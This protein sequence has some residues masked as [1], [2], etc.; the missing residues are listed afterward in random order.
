MV[1]VAPHFRGTVRCLEAALLPATWC[2]GG[3][4]RWRPPLSRFHRACSGGQVPFFHSSIY[5]SSLEGAPPAT[6]GTGSYTRGGLRPPIVLWPPPC[7]TYLVSWL[8][9][10]CLPLHP[11]PCKGQ[12]LLSPLASQPCVAWGLIW[13]SNR[14]A[15][16]EQRITT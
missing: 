11:W 9:A 13:N 1:A 3:C 2:E 10:R 8:C 7:S 12:T 14:D 6:V 5:P 16:P 15:A 4:L